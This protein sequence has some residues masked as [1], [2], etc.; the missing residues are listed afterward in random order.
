MTEKVKVTQKQFEA[1]EHR[2]KQAKYFSSER[3]IRCHVECDDDWLEGFK[4]LNKMPLI[5]LIDALRIGYE[6]EQE[7]KVGDFVAHKETGVVKEVTG[8]L[9]TFFNRH[10]FDKVNLRHA[11]PAEIKGEKERRLWKSTGRGV[12]EFKDFDSVRLRNGTSFTVGVTLLMPEINNQ[13]DKGNI[14]GFYP[15][16]S[17][18]SF[19]E[20]EP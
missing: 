15:A 5:K 9:E 6:I 8:D 3:I 10:Y 19:V 16:E 11:T 18:I 13:Y 7:Y 4:G 20:V 1:L 17:F 14:T 2:K 12:G